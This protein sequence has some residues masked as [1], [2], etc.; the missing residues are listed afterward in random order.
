METRA[1]TKNKPAQVLVSFQ[2]KRYT[3][4]VSKTPTVGELGRELEQV[5][6]V[7]D[8]VLLAPPPHGKVPLAQGDAADVLLA[9]IGIQ[10]NNI[11]SQG[12][13]KS[14]CYMVSRGGPTEPQRVALEAQAKADER[15][16]GFHEERRRDLQRKRRVPEKR[17]LPTGPYVFQSFKPLVIPGLNAPGVPP[18][19]KAL[20]LLH[21]LASDPGI[22]WVMNHHKW[23]VGVLSEMPPWGKVGVSEYCVLGYNVNKGQEI[24]L[25]LRTDDLKGFRKYE[26]I[27]TTLI[28]ELAHMVWSEHDVNF[29]TLN[30]QL[31]VESEKNDWTRSQART[32]NGDSGPA[33]D[34]DWDSSDVEDEDDVMAITALSSGQALGG[35]RS[36]SH[37]TVVD[38]RIK[39]RDAA[40]QRAEVAR[41]E[42]EMHVAK[43][44]ALGRKCG[45]ALCGNF[46]LRK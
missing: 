30:S 12:R 36:D 1:E 31:T 8:L 11:A 20:Q 2:G 10:A 9:D 14:K 7:A 37:D 44:Q 42:G 13:G 4:G 35:S 22:V 19:S 26:R 34:G 32:L 38:P 33:F 17:L 21:R 45:C 39:A 3:V 28:H 23:S 46:S 25:R 15:T 18:A 24:A 41:A 29:K 43:I 40:L 5:T 6:G 27:R 16:A